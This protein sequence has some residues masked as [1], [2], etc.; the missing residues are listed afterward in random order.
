[1]NLIPFES[2]KRISVKSAKNNQNCLTQFRIWNY[3]WTV[4]FQTFS[5]PFFFSIFSK[6]QF[7]QFRS[8]YFFRFYLLK[9]LT[10]LFFLLSSRRYSCIKYGWPNWL[11]NWT[12]GQKF[13]F[14]FPSNFCNFFLFW[15]CKSRNNKQKINRM[16]Q[17]K[18]RKE[19]EENND[20]NL[21]STNVV[22][23]V[24]CFL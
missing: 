14:Y 1:M 10:I 18:L 19:E 21:Q 15:F 4:N 3:V 22:C 20:K 11:L 12:E 17:M 23:F 6:T 8:I 24:C 7:I 5:F 16:N 13:I 9:C 2:K